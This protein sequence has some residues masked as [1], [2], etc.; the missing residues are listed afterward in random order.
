MPP[1]FLFM[2]PHGDDA[3][4]DPGRDADQQ[5]VVVDPN[6]AVAARR[7]GKAVAAIVAHLAHVAPFGR[8]HPMAFLP[9]MLWRNEPLRRRHPLVWRRLLDMPAS[10]VVATMMIPG[11]CHRG[12]KDRGGEQDDNELLHVC[13]LV[14][15]TLETR[16]WRMNPI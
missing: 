12:S 2:S 3:G 15:N 7:R 10:V 13:F 1:F 6:P 11:L 9:V 14:L 4:N 16:G 8:G 5:E